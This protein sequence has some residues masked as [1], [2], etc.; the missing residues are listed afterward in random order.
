VQL[1]AFLVAHRLYACVQVIL[2]YMKTIA[3]LFITLGFFIPALASASATIT[4]V[5]LNG[6]SSVSVDPGDTIVVSV[7]AT[8]TDSTKWKGTGWG[9]TS[10]AT[11]PGC[12]N[13]KNA[14]EGTRNNQTGVFTETFSIKAPANPGLYNANFWADEANKCGKPLG[15]VFQKAASV[16][17]G[18]NTPPDP[19]PYVM[20]AQSD[21]SYLCGGVPDS[22][23]GTWQYCDNS[24]TFG[25]TD[26]LESIPS[27]DMKTINLGVGSSMGDG[28]LKSVTIANTPNDSF[29]PWSITFSCYTDNAYTTAC[30]DWDSV[31]EP[32]AQSDDQVHWNADF[33]AD[34]VSFAP[35]RYYQMTIDDRIED[36]AFPAPAYGSF[37]LQE[38]YY[39]VIGLH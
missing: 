36:F 25:F 15:P 2:G 5:T 39:V 29:H 7:T 17:V 19:G 26:S 24:G 32:A 34:A 22:Y 11:T 28:I 4:S 20:K 13:T 16:R 31:S 33:S 3:T 35:A 18:A 12:T 1:V 30:S 27:G 37:S 10:N 21:E 38:P 8:L 23:T 6:A 9:I 14:K